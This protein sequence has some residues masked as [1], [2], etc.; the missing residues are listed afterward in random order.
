[1]KGCGGADGVLLCA[2]TFRGDSTYGPG[3][4]QFGGFCVISEPFTT[5][6]LSI[7]DILEI[8]P[9]EDPIVAIE[10]DGETLWEALENSLSAWPSQEGFVLV[11]KSLRALL[12]YDVI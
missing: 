5:G 3:L 8:L 12:T 9:F 11:V 2:G 4:P 1:M 10:I 6:F 7:G